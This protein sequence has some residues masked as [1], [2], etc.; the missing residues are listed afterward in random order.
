VPTRSGGDIAVIASLPA[1]KTRRLRIDDIELA[2]SE[3]PGPGRPFV[4]LHGLTGHRDDFVHRLP[5]LAGEA[6]LLAPDL[7]GHGDCT[8]TGRPETFTFARLID[9]LDALLDVSGADDCDLLGHS[10]GG[11]V[12]LRFALARP[13]RV[14]SL[15]LM[16]TAPCA[17][18]GYESWT[19]ERAGALARDRGM[20]FLQ[21]IVEKRWRDAPDQAG[22]HTA[23]WTDVYWPHHR[24]RYT[25]MDPVAYGCLGTAMVE[26]API[27]ERLH[28][29]RC[30]TSVV[31]GDGDEE[32]LPGADALERGIPHAVRET[33]PD[34]GHH[35]HMEN[36]AAWLAAVRAHLRRARGTSGAEAGRTA[37]AATPSPARGGPTRS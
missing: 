36:P 5:D 22:A 29:I 37:G 23:K 35:P 14:A 11:M 17:P 33:I 8:R 24:R 15:V 12:A 34:A 25:A 20:A 1:V 26:Q 31:V 19:F 9:D 27:T 13:E 4:L 7:R 30:P 10:F 21:A 2:C 18:E 28:E 16:G 3:V 6:R 32:F